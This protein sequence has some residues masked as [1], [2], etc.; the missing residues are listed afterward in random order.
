M[1]APET[2]RWRHGT[3]TAHS[4]AAARGRRPDQ[5]VDR[6]CVA[7][8]RRAR[9]PPQRARRASHQDRGGH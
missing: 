5:V 8:G 3:N 1:A 4:A 9:A 7:C 6:H 2:R